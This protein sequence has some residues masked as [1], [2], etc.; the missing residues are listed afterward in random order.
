[1]ISN[2]LNESTHK[3]QDVWKAF[4]KD[5]QINGSCI[6]FKDGTFSL[7]LDAL[8]ENSLE[9]CKSCGF[10]ELQFD[11]LRAFLE[12]LEHQCLLTLF[13]AFE[14][15]KSRHTSQSVNSCSPSLENET[16]SAQVIENDISLTDHIATTF[17][18]GVHS[19]AQK[20]GGA[21]GNFGEKNC[22]RKRM[23]QNTG[24]KR[25]HVSACPWENS[26]AVIEK[27]LAEH[28]DSSSELGRGK[29]KK[30]TKMQFDMSNEAQSQKLTLVS[31]GKRQASI[32]DAAT[33]K[34]RPEMP[35]CKMS[36]SSG[37][38]E[39]AEGLKTSQKEISHEKDREDD[40]VKLKT[41]VFMKSEEGESPEK[42][43]EEDY[44]ELE[45]DEDFKSPA[46]SGRTAKL[47]SKHKPEEVGER[48]DFE[49]DDLAPIICS[50]CKEKLSKSRD[51]IRH[52]K[53]IHKTEDQDTPLNLFYCDVCHESF[54]APR[55]F[56]LHY[57][58]HSGARPH[59]CKLCVK[60][61]RIYKGLKDHMM[62][63]TKEK[64]FACP[65]CPKRFVNKK[66]MNHHIKV[67]NNEVVPRVCELCGK[68]YQTLLGLK[69]HYRVHAGLRPHKCDVCGMAFTQRCSLQ[70]HKRLHTGDKRHICDVCGWRFN[71]NNALVTH[72]RVHT[73]ERPY[74]CTQCPFQAA[75]SS[76][77]KDHQIV[78][79]SAKPFPC[80]APGC[81]KY[82]KRQAH[83]MTHLKK[84]HS[85]L[86]P[87]ACSLCNARFAMVSELLHHQKSDACEGGRIKLETAPEIGIKA[88]VDQSQTHFESET[89]PSV[90][91]AGLQTKTVVVFE[92]QSSG[93]E[94][95]AAPRVFANGQSN[96]IENPGQEFQVSHHKLADNEEN[97]IVIHIVTEPGAEG[98]EVVLSEEEMAAIVR[99]S[100][101]I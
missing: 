18:K 80:H 9:V 97:Q 66:L 5:R 49:C 3:L 38:G 46:V 71:T 55:R 8:G 28:E 70:I 72:R 88:E 57:R 90:E 67:H 26:A 14:K 40:S 32:K 2:T 78:H 54:Q 43:S 64:P 33:K 4:C 24:K 30:F 69:L 13:I 16:E 7:I 56:K 82:F 41:A 93:I 1:M 75:S 61:F 25:R 91:G 29:R 73:G 31:K 53:L 85:G 20:G 81:N 21:L 63:H 60:K 100:Q 22:S 94:D 35:V 77:L 39:N 36:Q 99:L 15:F 37:N 74:K 44:R 47:G 83:L 48:T 68:Q 76:C 89:L 92:N 96:L 42:S 10:T 65:Q 86:K 87:Y 59:S 58:I 79:S 6:A 19:N 84:K 50:M 51:L 95:Q 101:Q 11:Q 27:A 52:W 23:I 45:S 98:A 12:K 62:C 34:G 17:D